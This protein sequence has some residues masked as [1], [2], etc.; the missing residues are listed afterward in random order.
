[1]QT[2]YLQLIIDR[3]PM[4]LCDFLILIILFFYVLFRD[5]SISLHPPFVREQLSSIRVYSNITIFQLTSNWKEN[6]FINNYQLTIQLNWMSGVKKKKILINSISKAV[7]SRCDVVKQRPLQMAVYY[8]WNPLV[9]KWKGKVWK[10]K[11]IL[12]F[13]T[14]KW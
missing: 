6:I 13:W 11:L 5:I 1:M 3:W 2:K 10:W 14:D 4:F 7:L 9:L 12:Q 8:C